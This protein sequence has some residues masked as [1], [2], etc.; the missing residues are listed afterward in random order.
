MQ[1]VQH[2]PR[3]ADGPQHPNRGMAMTDA[4]E[5]ALVLNVDL[6]CCLSASEVYVRVSLVWTGGL[7]AR[8]SWITVVWRAPASRQRGSQLLLGAIQPQAGLCTYP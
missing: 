3:V 6:D 7:A 2:Y 1:H 4:S 5:V 8:I